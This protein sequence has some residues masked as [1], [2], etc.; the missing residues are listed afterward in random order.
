MP[1]FFAVTAVKTVTVIKAVSAVETVPT[2]CETAREM[3]RE[4]R[5][6]TGEKMCHN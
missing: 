5:R 4:H 6:V 3:T 2:T 1:R